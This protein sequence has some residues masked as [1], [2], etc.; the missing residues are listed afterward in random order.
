M[1]PEDGQCQ[2]ETCCFKFLYILISN[3]NIYQKKLLVVL[4]TASP[5]RRLVYYTTGIANLKIHTEILF[6]YSPIR[7]ILFPVAKT[8]LCVFSIFHNYVCQQKPEY[9]ATKQYKHICD[10]RS[11]FPPHS[12]LCNTKQCDKERRKQP[13]K[14]IPRKIFL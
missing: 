14:G 8:F 2:A 7:M 10:W 4:L 11:F 9:V 6:I 5:Y 3:N 13:F 12:C 1:K